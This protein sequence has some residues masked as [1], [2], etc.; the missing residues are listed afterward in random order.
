MELKSPTPVEFEAMKKIRS[1]IPFTF[2]NDPTLEA[3]FFEVFKKYK[4]R[5]FII[6]VI[7]YHYSCFE[8]DA[9]G[10]IKAK[11]FLESLKKNLNVKVFDF[12]HAVYPDSLFFN[13]EHLNYQGAKRFSKELKDSID[14]IQMVNRIN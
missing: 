1:Q 2:K 14:Q 9:R 8:N 6:S 13:T 10:Y 7:P 5:L 11:A 3:S 4:Q 12:S